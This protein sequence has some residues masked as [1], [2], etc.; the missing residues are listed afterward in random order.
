VVGL[1]TRR[2]HWEHATN[3]TRRTICRSKEGEGFVRVK[4]L[5]TV[6]AVPQ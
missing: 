1:S 3:M 4:G 6:N 5:R 2:L